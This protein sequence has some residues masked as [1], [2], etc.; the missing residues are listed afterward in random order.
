M[1]AYVLQASLQ[2]MHG[3]GSVFSQDHI[4]KNETIKSFCLRRNAA[5]TIFCPQKTARLH[6]GRLQQ[7]RC[8]VGGVNLDRD[9]RPELQEVID[10]AHGCCLTH[11][12]LDQTVPGLGPKLEGKVRDTYDAGEFLVLVTTDRQSAF[13]RVLASIPFKG[14]VLNQTS[15]WWFS[16]TQHI[17]PNAFV[18]AP[19]PNVTIASKC[20]V[21]PVEF[22]VRGFITGTTSTSLWTVYSAGTRS[23]CGNSLPEGMVKNE[24]LAHNMLTPTTKAADHDEPVTPHEIVERGLMTQAEF[25]DVRDKALRL[26]AHGQEVAREHGL[27]LVDT[28]YEFGRDASGCIVLIDEVHTPDSSRYWVAASYEERHAGGLEPESIDKEFLRLWFRNNCDPYK[29]A[30]LPEAPAHLVSE[31]SWRYIVLYETITGCKFEAPNLQEPIHDAM[32]RAVA[33]ALNR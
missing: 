27:L 11:T 32:T 33:V 5:M 10:S 24:K 3:C 17:T 7:A 26:F 21:F 13:D 14:Q 20:H 4:R 29:D 25:E 12:F 6:V 22:V 2:G 28:K 31:L 1:A 19:H 15:A 30:V 18:S 23:Y 9:Q 16:T 8:L